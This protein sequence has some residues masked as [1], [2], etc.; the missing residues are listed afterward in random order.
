[1]RPICLFIGITI[2]T[3]SNIFGQRYTREELLNIGRHMQIQLFSVSLIFAYTGKRDTIPKL[4]LSNT[5]DT[6]IL[7]RS[8]TTQN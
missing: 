1:M 3:Q 6:N 2:I 7:H 4:I 5:N 8:K